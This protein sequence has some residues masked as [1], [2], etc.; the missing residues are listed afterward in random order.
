MGCHFDYLA[1]T[2]DNIIIFTGSMVL[3]HKEKSHDCFN[4]LYNTPIHQCSRVKPQPW[5]TSDTSEAPKKRSNIIYGHREKVDVE[6]TAEEL[7]KYRNGLS[8][9]APIRVVTYTKQ[10]VPLPRTASGKTSRGMCRGIF[11]GFYNT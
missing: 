3:R 11:G 10:G 7:Y 1:L 8:K 9:T 2:E 5:E 6:P 4:R